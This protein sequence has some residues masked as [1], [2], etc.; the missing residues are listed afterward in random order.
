ML[1]RRQSVRA[2]TFIERSLLDPFAD[3]IGRW[4][5]LARQLVDAPPGARQLNNSAPVLRR[6]RWMGSWHWGAPSSFLPTPS[7]KPGQLH[8]A[9]KCT[10]FTDF[11]EE[12]LVTERESR[13][14]RAREMF[15]RVAGFPAVKTLDQYDFNFTPGAPRKQIMELAS[16]AFVERAENVVFLGP[17]GIGKTHLAIA[18]GYLATQKGYK[19]RFLSA[20]D[21]VLMLEAAQRQGRYREVMH[22]AVNAY[23]LLILDE[24][25]YLPMSREQANLFFQVV[26]RRYERGSMIL[27][28]N[29]TFA[30]WDSAFAGDSVLTAAMLDRVL[31]HSAIVSING[32]SF[33]LKDKRKAGLLVAPG[34]TA[35]H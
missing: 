23:R 20:A 31:H 9:E 18:L 34:K 24:I 12:L 10:S 16:L 26:A 3:R 4:L 13:R 33:R 11:L 19:T 15:A 30:S 2:Q 7:T 17:S 6:V 29:L 14:A 1:G 21:L 25:G 28:S 8:A 27:T 5:E 32:E 35:K 22:R